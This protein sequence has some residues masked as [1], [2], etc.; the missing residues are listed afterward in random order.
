[1]SLDRILIPLDGSEL[2]EAILPQVQRLLLRTG[3]EVLLL[4]TVPYPPDFHI[5]LPTILEDAHRYI[6]RK[7][8]ELVN[9]GVRARGL[10]EQGLAAGTILEVA[11]RESVSLVAMSTHG[12]TGLS[13]WAFG[14]VA[15]KVLRA[16]PAPLLLLRSFRPGPGK[17]LSRGRLQELPFRNILVPVDGREASLSV[18]STV[19][20][21]ARPIDAHVTLLCVHEPSP[22]EG[23]WDS[24]DQP[25]A[26]AQELLSAACI[27][28]RTE[29]R[30]GDPA[31][32]ILRAADDLSADLIAMAT[33]GRSG[34]S[35]WVLGSV[36]EKVLHGATVPML[37]ARRKGEG[38]EE[39]ARHA[40]I[41]ALRT[42]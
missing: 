29:V 16:G 7:T 14:S 12:R 36:T 22:Y 17:A 15:E 41:D 19:L 32:E 27:P 2:A 28:V 39:S 18:L 42:P 9:S 25:A 24:A 33:H 23:R 38:A 30:K 21:I 6:R 34:P 10:V 13:R 26:A 5:A 31:L 37:V 20:E 3:S 40:G 35:R 4:Q 1:M 11:A 8:F